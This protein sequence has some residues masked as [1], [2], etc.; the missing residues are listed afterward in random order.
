MSHA[1]HLPVLDAAATAA[2][3]PMVALCQLLAQAAA[4]CVLAS[5]QQEQPA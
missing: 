5:S 4:R 3:L 1:T 2:P